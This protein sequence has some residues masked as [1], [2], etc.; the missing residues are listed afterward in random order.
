[1]RP[2][3]IALDPCDSATHW[4][5]ET[6]RAATA[7]S[8]SSDA[9]PGAGQRQGQGQVAG[10]TR[11]RSLPAEIFGPATD[12]PAAAFSSECRASYA[13]VELPLPQV[14]FSFFC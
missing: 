1:M 11:A 14:V 5:S 10:V 4:M 3:P 12:D 9:R 8:T 2:S 6:A 7:V 13:P